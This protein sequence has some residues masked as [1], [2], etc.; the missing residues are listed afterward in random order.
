ML[1]EKLGEIKMWT[2]ELEQRQK[3]EKY[4]FGTAW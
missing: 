2:R 1:E 3:N 4:L